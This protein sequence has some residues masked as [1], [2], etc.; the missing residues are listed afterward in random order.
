MWEEVLK[1]DTGGAGLAG[2]VVDGTSQGQADTALVGVANLGKRWRTSRA[3]T[4]RRRTSTPSA[5]SRGTGGENS[6][7]L[8]R[9]W[10]KMAWGVK[11]AVVDTVVAMMMG[12]WE[13]N[14]SYETPLGILRAP[15][16]LERPL[17]ADAERGGSSAT[18]GAPSTT[19]RPTSAGL[20]I[21]AA[22]PTGS[23]FAARYFSPLE[24]RSSS[25]RRRRP[26]TSPVW[27][28]HVPSGTGA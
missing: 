2:E 9:E 4:S 26:R 22:P 20:G 25:I 7:A 3:T 8:A 14:V 1:T 12:S 16:Q 11:Q 21:Q 6:E 17:R 28:H 27:F 5:G 18:T 13:A 24:E 23:N 10:T 15:V 19:T